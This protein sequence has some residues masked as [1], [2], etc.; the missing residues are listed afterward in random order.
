[1]DIRSGLVAEEGRA[2]ADADDLELF[3][4]D[5][6]RASSA[7]PGI[8]CFDACGAL[9]VVAFLTILLEGNGCADEGTTESGWFDDTTGT[10]VVFVTVVGALD[11]VF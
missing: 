1:M 11:A 3:N 5:V 10:G 6:R 9:S 7:L 8:G 2:L 4:A